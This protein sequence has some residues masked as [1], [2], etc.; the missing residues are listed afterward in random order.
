MRTRDL[1]HTHPISY[2]WFITAL[3]HGYRCFIS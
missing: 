1:I 2:P 3:I